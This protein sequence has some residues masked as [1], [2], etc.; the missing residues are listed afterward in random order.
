VEPDR[1]PAAQI[2]IKMGQAYATP[3]CS[4]PEPFS[5]A[6]EAVSYQKQLAGACRAAT[7]GAYA[8]EPDSSRAGVSTTLLLDSLLTS[9]QLQ[10]G[11]R[12]IGLFAT[13]QMAPSLCGPQPT[14]TLVV[15]PSAPWGLADSW[16]PQFDSLEGRVLGQHP[17]EMNLRCDKDGSSMAA[18]SSSGSSSSSSSGSSSSSSS[19]R[20]HSSG[21]LCYGSVQGSSSGAGAG[22]P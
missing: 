16:L 10:D 2:S 1:V 20:G 12:G 5:A 3:V 6:W 4:G 14:G 21:G 19:S 15:L 8:A 9:V 18:S 17:A 22:R 7:A 11:A 13:R